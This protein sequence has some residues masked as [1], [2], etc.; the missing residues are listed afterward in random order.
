M[1]HTRLIVILFCLLA[2]GCSNVSGDAPPEPT[3]IEQTPEPGTAGLEATATLPAATAT[4]LPSPT[5]AEPTATAS[6]AVTATAT[7]TPTPSPAPTAVALAVAEELAFERVAHE[8]GEVRSVAVDGNIA[9][10][11]LG[12]R[13]VALDVSNPGSPQQIGRSE[14]LPGLVDTLVLA[15]D[16]QQT[17]VYAGAGRHVATLVPGADGQIAVEGVVVMPGIVRALALAD[18]LLYAGGIVLREEANAEDSGFIAVVEV[19]QP[20]ALAV[21]QSQDAPYPVTSL[22]LKN[23]ALFYSGDYGWTGVRLAVMDVSDGMLGESRPVPGAELELYSLRVIGDTLV[24]GGYG[25]V[26]AFDIADPHSPQ[27]LWQVEGVDGYHLGMVTGFA[28]A[29]GQLYLSGWQPAGAYIPFRRALTPPEPLSGAPGAP[30]SA[31][32]VLSGR[33]LYVAEAGDLEIYD[34][35]R[36]GQLTQVGGYKPFPSPL[37]DLALRSAS[38][39]GELLYLYAGSPF[40]SAPEEL[41]TLRLP[42]LEV[43]G[44]LS[45]AVEDMETALSQGSASALAMGDGQAYAVARDGIY[46][47]DLSEPAAPELAGR[48]PFPEPRGDPRG[49]VLLDGQL[50]LGTGWAFRVDVAALTPDSAGVLT[51]TQ[52]VRRGRFQSDQLMAMAGAGDSLYVTT[53]AGIDEGWLH[54]V[55]VRDELEVVGTLP[56]PGRAE[57]VI[58]VEGN[59]VAT[60]VGYEER[61]DELL[62]ID[63]SAP[64]APAIVAQVSLAGLVEGQPRVHSLALKDGLLFVVVNGQQVLVI[65][66]TEPERPRGVGVVALPSAYPRPGVELAVGDEMIVA[67]SGAMGVMLFT[68]ED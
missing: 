67:G 38:Q 63:V 62:L 58:A 9:Y 47:I 14:A 21:L 11:G 41:L 37:S 66:V 59:L 18:G 10:V 51:Q 26:T 1:N 13:L 34:V 46:T 57:G 33:R 68:F 27:R 56:L 39:D 45:F 32:V 49:V 54:V 43:V 53:A 29:V 25:T 24:V 4:A 64:A 44:R 30:A 35:S 50:Y 36:P 2:I 6:P 28:L 42:S 60:A 5:P 65:D 48:Y 31:D 7:G 3:Q 16:G 61:G 40:D 52:T 17:R 55:D 8:G 23:G 22:A 12:P 20:A 15:N 19:Q